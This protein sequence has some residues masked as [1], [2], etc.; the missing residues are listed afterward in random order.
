MRVACACI[1]GTVITIYPLASSRPN[2][3][4]VFTREGDF[5]AAMITRHTSASGHWIAIVSRYLIT[6][7]DSSGIIILNESYLKTQKGLR[8][9]RS[10][11]ACVR[12]YSTSTF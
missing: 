8:L 2:R 9:L 11:R 7:A 12:W 3:F 5:L 4:G 10:C 1:P 6:L